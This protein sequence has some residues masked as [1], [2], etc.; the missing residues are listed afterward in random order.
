M[1][2]A[3]IQGIRGSYSEEAASKYFGDDVEIAECISFDE[4]LGSARAGLADFAVIPQ[5]NSIIGDIRSTAD[6]L[7][8]CGMRRIDEINIEIEHV[9]AGTQDSSIENI[10]SVYSHI[11]ALRQCSAFFASNPHLSQFPGS[12]TASSVRAIVTQ[13]VNAKAA[14]CS[15]RAVDIYGA[16]ILN[17]HVGD[18]RNN[19][20]TFA[21]IGN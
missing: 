9:L 14:I 17:Q 12:D 4:A 10:T 6:L 20:T 2:K 11:E 21:I 13:G 19:R 15:K 18:A 3:A 16:R 7:K 5:R 1:T 8:K